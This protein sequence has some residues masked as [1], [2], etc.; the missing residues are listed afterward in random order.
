M[1]KHIDIRAPQHLSNRPNSRSETPTACLVSLR[2]AAP[3]HCVGFGDTMDSSCQLRHSINKCCRCGPEQRRLHWFPTGLPLT[4]LC[5]PHFCRPSSRY[6]GMRSNVGGGLGNFFRD[7]STNP[8]WE[9]SL[10][11]N[12]ACQPVQ[13]FYTTSQKFPFGASR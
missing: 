7:S 10:V 6:L 2:H 3:S 13:I 5:L 1:G 8:S 9:F 12:R 4:I 11:Y